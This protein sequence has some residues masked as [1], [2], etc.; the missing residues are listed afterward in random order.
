MIEKEK[1]YFSREQLIA[2]A[3]PLGGKPIQ[4]RT[5]LKY[6]RLT[7]LEFKPPNGRRDSYWK[8]QCECGRVKEIRAASLPS[9]QSCGCIH[10]DIASQ[11][12]KRMHRERRKSLSEAICL[13]REEV[14]SN[15]EFFVFLNKYV[16]VHQRQRRWARKVKNGEISLID[17]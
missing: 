13:W 9:T 6:G 7:A 3:M 10:K 4:D 14:W 15:N 12:S 8:C 11:R 16:T 2:F 17:P 1:K 5:G